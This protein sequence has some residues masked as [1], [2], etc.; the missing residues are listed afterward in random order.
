MKLVLFYLL[1]SLCVPIF[2]GHENTFFENRDF[3]NMKIGKNITVTITENETVDAEHLQRVFDGELKKE[4]PYF[5]L[6]DNDE[7]K[8]MI[9]YMKQNDYVIVPGQYTFNQ[10][11]HFK[12][13]VFIL[14]SGK[15]LE[16]F[17]FQTKEQ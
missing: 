6:L 14:N 10:G 16:V 13:G 2:G 12:N 1:L 15:T 8:N 7:L 3:W 17:K 9:D 5:D 4:I 11:W